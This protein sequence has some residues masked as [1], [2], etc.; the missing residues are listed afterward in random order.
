MDIDTDKLIARFDS[1]CKIFQKYFPDEGTDKF[2]EDFGTRLVT[3]PRGLTGDDG[4]HHGA[5][6]EFLTTVALQAKTISDGVCDQTS[7]VRVALVHELGKLGS[8]EQQLYVEQDSS[9]HREK[10]GQNFKYNENCE[11]MTVPHRTLYLL[12]QYG[13]NLSQDEWI[14]VLVSQGAQYQETSF[15]A[16]DLSLLSSVLNFSRAVAAG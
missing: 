11:R 2:L 9:W 16:K 3:C 10:L 7:A 6:L 15:Y 14:A 8:L 13:I 5:L 1:Y 4:G 12:Q